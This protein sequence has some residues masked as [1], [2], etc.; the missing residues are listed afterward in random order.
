MG[1][2]GIGG[3][4]GLER[5]AQRLAKLEARA[6]IRIWGCKAYYYL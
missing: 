1:L 2:G 3:P 4:S 5:A 6:H